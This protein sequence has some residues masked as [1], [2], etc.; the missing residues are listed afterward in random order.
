M[1]FSI[2]DSRL[3]SVGAASII[4]VGVLGVGSVAFAQ[5]GGDGT[6]PPAESSVGDRHHGGIKPLRSLLGEA[7]V[8]KEEVIEGKS[9]GLT[10][11]EIID[12]YGDISSEEAKANALAALEAKLAEAVAS[13]RIAQEKA[14]EILANAPA[15]ID[16]FLASTPGE[17]RP[18]IPAKIAHFTLGTVAEVLGVEPAAIIEQLQ[19]GETIADI[20]GDQAQAVIDALVAE[21]SAKIDEAV[22]AGRIDADRAEEIKAELPAKAEQFVNT[23]HPGRA[24]IDRLRDR[25]GDREGLRGRLGERFGN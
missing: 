7:G 12:T 14:D 21:A 1:K 25:L 19:A 15:R 6:P 22:A 4:A 13:G 3:V 8:T 11:G 5:E 9:A 24:A 23:E 10:W 18:H 20:A 16:E 2:R 17:N